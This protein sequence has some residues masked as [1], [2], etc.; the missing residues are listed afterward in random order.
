MLSGELQIKEAVPY[1]F[2][3]FNSSDFMTYIY[4]DCLNALGTIGTEEVVKEIENLYQPDNEDRGALAGIPGKIPF[5]YSENLAIKLLQIE[6]GKSEKASIACSL[7][8]LFSKKAIPYLEKLMGIHTY[9]T[10]Y[11]ELLEALVSLYE[12]YNLKY[13][14]RLLMEDKKYA[15][16]SIKL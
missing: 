5:E 13:P 15:L 3:I 11:L 7:C 2:K 8:D 6:K 16:K 4:S 1:L 12:Y 10:N 9:D 14:D